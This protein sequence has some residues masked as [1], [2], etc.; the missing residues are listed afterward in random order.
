MAKKI[1][2]VLVAVLMVASM[3]TMAI[4][5]ASAAEAPSFSGGTVYW[6]CPWATAKQAYCHVYGHEGSKLYDWQTKDEKMTKVAGTDNTWSYE[7]PAGSY[8]EI[9]FSIDLGAQTYDLVLTDDNINDTAVSDTDTPLEN[10]MDSNKTGAKTTWKSG[11]NGPHLGITSIGNIGGDVLCPTESGADIVANFIATY[12]SIQPE[13]VT[14]EVLKDAMN[15][16]GT[17]GADVVAVLE[18]KEDFTL[19]DDAKKLLGVSGGEN[20][21]SANENSSSNENSSTGSTAST[22]SNRSN[23]STTSKTS[24]GTTTTGDSTPFVVLGIVLVAALGVA[25]VAAKKKVSE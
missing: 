21:S 14:E 9:I 8:D 17:S 20:N 7:I 11:K 15:K 6:E 1:L 23:T 25:V 12:L 4:G 19:L 18:T 3:A 22:S 10:P 16:A 24:S 5:T 13:Y 2:S